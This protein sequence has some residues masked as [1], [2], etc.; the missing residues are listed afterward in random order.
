MKPENAGQVRSSEIITTHGPGALFNGKEGVSVMILGLDM[1][2]EAFEQTDNLGK[3]RVIHNK[4]L[5]DV[6]HKDHFRMPSGNRSGIPCSVFP[7]WGYCEYC[8]I[9]S[10][11][12]GKPDKEK[13]YYVCKY[14]RKENGYKNKILPAR[15]I[16]LCDYGHVQDFPWEEW[17]HS[18][19]PYQEAGFCDDPLV[20]WRFGRG[21]TT[22]S[23][24]K[25]ICKTCNKQRSM[26]GATDHISA[27]LPQKNGGTFELRCNGNS[28]WL[29]RNTRC[30][31]QGSDSNE[32]KHLKGNHV[33]A[34]NMYFPMTVSALQI[35]RFNNPVQKTIEKNQKVIEYLRKKQTSLKEIAAE[36]FFSE[37][38]AT[39]DK[40]IDE[41]NYRFN[42]D[43]KDENDI[44]KEEYDDLVHSQN[45]TS[46]QNNEISISGIEVSP[47]LSPY[48]DKVKRV[49]RLT[50]ISV[51]RSFTRGNP[52]DP[53]DYD[54]PINK[55]R[56]KIS[57]NPKIDW[58]PCVETKGEGI[59]FT[60]NKDRVKRWAENAGTIARCKR[61][62]DCYDEFSS[63]R[64]M[65]NQ[66]SSPE[67]ILLHTLAH[68]LIRELA[69]ASGYGESSIRERI[70]H[71]DQANAILLYTS[72]NASE[73][74]LGGLVRNA[75]TD[76]FSSVLRGAI[77]K[78]RSC[79]RDPLCVE[80]NVDS[81][82]INTRLN[83][84]ACYACSLLPETSCE[85][86]NRLLDR[87]ILGDEKVGFF[88]D[89]E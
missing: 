87:K 68:V 58:L 77:S 1:W 38:D 31:P 23:N 36:D 17:A 16:L 45:V 11:M 72:S 27:S 10:K 39:I 7:T 24:Y 42:H 20:K 41:L 69:Y 71:D 15:L 73:G 88:G 66:V 50:M 26:F 51:L 64:K 14:C 54:N 74:S 46:A 5:E 48:I 63:R 33:R 61:I 19:T 70:Y 9:M 57:K 21:G 12:E 13:G 56:C 84:S 29:G 49:D 79:S 52:P 18:K 8:H 67:Y 40:V 59:F 25:V 80:S 62:I 82:P 47:E 89:L 32:K 83:G 3:F 6:C 28:P 81:G 53:Y 85:N 55:S 86:F 30:P 34:S 60:L 76:E 37:V 4:F 44:K 65:S 22:L 2:S 43:V 78:S 75:E 35:P